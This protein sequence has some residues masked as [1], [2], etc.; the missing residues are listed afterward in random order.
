MLVHLLGTILLATLAASITDWMFMDLLVHRFYA[1]EPG[2]WRPSGGS[3]RIVVSQVIGT[4]ATAA[5]VVLALLV[6]GRPLTV[7]LAGWCAGPLPVCL[8]Q[9]QWMRVHPVIAASHATGWL[10]RL[11]IGAGLAAWWLHAG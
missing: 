7:A 4:L 3:R 1:R 2:V 6:P 9:A 11:L 8:Q 10:V 5:I